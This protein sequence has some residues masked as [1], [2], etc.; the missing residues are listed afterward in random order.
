MSHLPSSIFTLPLMFLFVVLTARSADA[1]LLDRSRYYNS[2]PE[3]SPYMEVESQDGV[4]RFVPLKESHLSGFVEGPLATLSLAQKYSFTKAQSSQPIEALYRFPLPGDAAVKGAAVRFGDVEIATTL[5][6][7]EEARGEYDAARSEGRQAVL[8]SRESGKSFTM[9]ITGIEPDVTVEVLVDFVAIARPIESGWELRFPL[10]VPPRYVRADEAGTPQA[11]SNPLALAIDPGHRFSMELKIRHAKDIASPTHEIVVKNEAGVSTTTL[12]LGA[13]TPDRDLLL[14]WKPDVGREAGGLL[15]TEEDGEDTYFL[16]LAAAGEH[17]EERQT[18]KREVSLLI[19][20]SG[21]MEGAKWE[22]ADW[23]AKKFLSD[24][25]KDDLFDVA[26]F[27]DDVYLFSD[28]MLEANSKNVAKA[29]EFVM[30]NRS[31]GGTELGVALERMLMIP[32]AEPKESKGTKEKIARQLLVITDAQVTDEG[33]ILE[34]VRREYAS[35]SKR[36][37]SVLCIDASPND[38]LTNR[39]AERGG[40]TA[41]YL[42]SNPEAE[43][44]TTAVDEILS[45]WSR[46]VAESVALE[47]GAQTLHVAGRART[48]SKEQGKVEIELGSLMGGEPLWI[49]GKISGFKKEEPVRVRFDERHVDVAADSVALERKQGRDSIR[50]LYG[51]RQIQELE[52]LK[53]SRLRGTALRTELRDELL[54]LGYK[55]RSEKS[56]VYDENENSIAQEAVDELLLTE[57]LKYG[58][59]STRTAFVASRT[60]KGKLVGDTL[61][62]PNALPSGWDSEVL[63]VS[64]SYFAAPAPAP[65]PSQNAPKWAKKRSRGALPMAMHGG[66]TDVGYEVVSGKTSIYD[67]EVT[68]PGAGEV[69]LGEVDLKEITGSGHLSDLVLSEESSLWNEN[70]SKLFIRVYVDGNA[71]PSVS[72]QLAGLEKGKWPL[73]LTYGKSVRFVLANESDKNVTLSNLSLFVWG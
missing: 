3:G 34:L 22:A 26:F 10:T 42:T 17:E 31:S 47:L 36:R 5:K 13:V 33:R 44:V 23:A 37:I 46:P 66:N 35:D 56:K 68:V 65:A 40:G 21:S 41:V 67:S 1:A 55:V 24:L 45:R 52:F 12:A 54:S 49:V 25:G 8:L 27:H 32:K 50:T 60:E 53:T 69:G 30:K 19:D 63:S 4:R 6:E 20:H 61:L 70:L 73:N 18:L 71:K 38:T 7:R 14:S 43:D 62:T 2:S 15:Y 16:L 57:S 58:I 39:L 48:T 9:S 28:K 72:V 51:A 59:V 11:D 29:I 64:A